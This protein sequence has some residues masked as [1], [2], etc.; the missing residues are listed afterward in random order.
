METLDDLKGGWKQGRDLDAPSLPLKS[1]EFNQLINGRIKKEQRLVWH[2]AVKTYIWSV[3]VFSY[4]SYLMITSW[5]D[6]RL[7]AVCAVTMAIY[8]IFTTVFMKRFKRFFAV[9]C[10]AQQALD[11]RQGLQMKLKEL[12][13]F[14][15][16]KR[17]FDWIMIPL[18]CMVIA[19][20]VNNLAFDADFTEHLW[21]NMCT[22]ILYSA[23]FT[24]VT[25]RDNITYFKVPMEKLKA[26]IKDMEG[27]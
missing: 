6:W 17:I 23:A 9:E 8:I 15:Q 22:F 24:Y 20:S 3:M 16:F 1:T 5:G 7:F 13:G 10:A 21:F 18:S 11:L 25:F 14:Y 26:V 27:D 12:N 2:Y 19:L 4:L